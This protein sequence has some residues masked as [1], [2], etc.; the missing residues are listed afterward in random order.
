[1]DLS[2]SR[3]LVFKYT[4]KKK[5]IQNQKGPGRWFRDRAQPCICGISFLAVEENKDTNTT[6]KRDKTREDKKESNGEEQ[7]EKTW[8][9][10]QEAYH[11]GPGSP[12]DRAR[13]LVQVW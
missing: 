13:N 5:Y 4:K 7:Y 1:M 11:L 12:G 2:V 10:K 9:G 8:K 6:N 3:N